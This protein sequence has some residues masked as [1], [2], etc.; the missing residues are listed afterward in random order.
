MRVSLI[1]ITK[2]RPEPLTA[3]LECAA[4]A[5]PADAELIVVDGD[6]QRSAEPVLTEL[7]ARYD[8]LDAR[9]LTSEPGMTV[10]RNV[11]IDAARGD[12]VVFVDD[13]CTFAP[14]L[15]EALLSAYADPAVVGVTG[16]IDGPRQPR[17]G[18]GPHSRLRWLILGGGRQGSM[19]SFGFRRPIVHLECPRDVEYMP[20]PLMSA[21]R[22]VAAQV[23]FDERLAGYSLG[24][25]DDF[26]YRASQRGR[27]R[28]EP[29][30]RV[31]HHVLGWSEADRREM[32]RRQIIDRIYLFRKNFPQTLSARARFAALLAL[33]CAHRFA[34][35]EWSGLRGL[36]EGMR[37]ARTSPWHATDSSPA[38][39]VT[40][41]AEARSVPRRA[42]GDPSRGTGTRPA[43]AAGRTRA[44][45][46]RSS[47]ARDGAWR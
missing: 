45:H 29:S 18:G 1:V 36:L 6:P 30:V 5:L 22:I 37:Q 32:D 28:Y 46:H 43:T 15:F 23:R 38:A 16:R 19:S 4:R 44:Q 41:A 21:R 47:K 40:A 34:N 11:G 26:S 8:D 20:G 24:E 14:G 35:R 10:Q 31:Y 13:D 12:V 17:L 33:L 39:T 27:I 3:V 2:N 7:R 9:Y 42:T 25:D